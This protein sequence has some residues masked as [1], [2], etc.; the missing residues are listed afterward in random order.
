MTVRSAIVLTSALVLGGCGYSLAGKGNFL[1]E[2]I[3]IIAIPTFANRTDR[4]AI[5]E[6]F[7]RKVVEEFTARGKYRIQADSAGADAVLEGTVVS[8]IATPTVLEGGSVDDAQASQASTYTVVV[9]AQVQFRDLVEEEVIWSNNN[10]QFRDDYE[11]GEN[12]EE[13][14]DQ[15]SLTLQRLAE[16]FSKSLVSS[17]LEAF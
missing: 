13:F 12:P 16:E 3:A 11:I 7:T 4:V 15:E 14:F 10:F 1:P 5:E 9:R 8:F 17:I 2:H 6:T